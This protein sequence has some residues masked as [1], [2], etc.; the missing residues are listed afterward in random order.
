[1]DELLTL[2]QN[3]ARTSVEDLAREL[4]TTPADVAERID[5]Y[6]RDG[7]I[8]GYRAMIS[9]DL[10]ADDRVTAVIEA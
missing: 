6:E 8:R 10:T 7:V 4:G 9:D 3:N 2:L 5:R 1:M